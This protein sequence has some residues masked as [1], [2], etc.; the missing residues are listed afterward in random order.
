[1][2]QLVKKTQML[3]L[4]AKSWNKRTFG[5]IFSQLKNIEELGNIQ[6]EILNNLYIGI[7]QKE[8]RLINKKEKILN[9]HKTY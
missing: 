8:A 2:F 5:N 1:M 7:I 6:T 3:K 9:F 4:Q